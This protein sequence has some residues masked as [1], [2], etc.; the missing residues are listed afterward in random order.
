MHISKKKN[1]TSEG[2]KTKR[3][4]DTHQL[5]NGL[6]V[7]CLSFRL[8]QEKIKLKPTYSQ[9]VHNPGYGIA[10]EL[11]IKVLVGPAILRGKLS[12]SCAGI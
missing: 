1:G 4:G 11:E 12:G 10:L 8:D 2:G 7:R 5:Q 9:T 3:T 6:S